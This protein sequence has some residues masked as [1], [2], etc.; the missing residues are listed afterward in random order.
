[1]RTTYKELLKPTEAEEKDIWDN[2]IIVFDTNILLNLYR[3]T[4]DTRDDLLAQMEAYIDQL[5]LP[6][7]VGWEY[8]NNRE[9]IINGLTKVYKEISSKLNEDKVKLLKYY[10]D[11]YSRHP[12]LKKEELTK[13]FDKAIE[14]ITKKLDEWKANT[15]DYSATDPIKD[16]LF[17]L[18]EGKVGTDLTEEEIKAAYQEGEERY[19]DKIPPGFKDISNKKDKGKR[20]LYGDLIIWKQI[21]KYAQETQKDIIFV[22]QDAKEDWWVKKEGKA[23]GPLYSLLKEFRASTGHALMMYKQE[24]FMK[25]A[26]KKKA[27][28]KTVKEVKAMT[29]E[30]NRSR[31]Q[32]MINHISTLPGIAIPSLANL[33]IPAYPS[34]N[35]DHG[36]PQSILDTIE[37]QRKISIA[38]QALAGFSTISEY[39]KQNSAYQIQENIR[40]LISGIDTLKKK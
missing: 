1:M 27:K 34:I 8:F 5:W 3:F 32:R 38:A 25:A 13:V 17:E 30:D 22:T 33:Q 37:Q 14:T 4:T 35:I 18:Y 6:Y 40:Q 12:I 21:I 10:D 11:N 29:E 16:K 23:E 7:Q 20:H 2:G 26:K 24:G 19:A 39:L 36:I 31:A 9:N 15:P 28:A